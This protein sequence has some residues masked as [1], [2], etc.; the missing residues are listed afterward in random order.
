MIMVYSAIAGKEEGV[1]EGIERKET[2][3]LGSRVLPKIKRL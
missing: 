1:V 2:K 3:R